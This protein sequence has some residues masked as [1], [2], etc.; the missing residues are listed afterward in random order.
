MSSKNVDSL[1]TAHEAWNRRDYDEVIRNCASNLS[2]TDHATSHTLSGTSQFRDWITNWAKAFPNGKITHPRYID[3]GDTV[4]AQ[5]TV[6]GTNDGSF[7]GLPPT[8]RN[9][10][11]DYCEVCQFDRKGQLSQV[12]CYYDLYTILTQLG[13]VEPLSLAA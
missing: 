10:R 11:F 6:E 12:S 9:S 3:A 2:Y 7:A 8:H 1:R 4:I 13:H 5:F